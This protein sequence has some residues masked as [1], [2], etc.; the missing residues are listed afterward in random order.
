MKFKIM[1]LT[2]LFLSIVSISTAD[3]LPQY[4][5]LDYPGRQGVGGPFVIDPVGPGANFNTF[6]VETNEYITLGGTYY[7][8]IE[9]YAVYGGADKGGINDTD[10]INIETK[11]LYDYALDHW[12]TLTIPE[13]TAI[14]NAIWAYEGEV[15]VASLSALAKTYYDNAPGYILDRNI[16]ALNLWTADVGGPPYNNSYAYGHKAQT[17]LIQVPEPGILA[18]LGIALSAVGL[19]A[20]RYRLMP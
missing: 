13:L 10:P 20:R 9:S 6:C 2:A 7:G 17:M 3:P 16:M 5:L 18:L 12:G 15:T 14:Q 19:A 1:C 4:T 8:S 11:K